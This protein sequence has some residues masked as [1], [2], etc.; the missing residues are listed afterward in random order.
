MSH[1]HEQRVPTPVLLGALTLIVLTIGLAASARDGV[2][3]E[4]IA[5]AQAPALQER[6]LRFQDRPDGAIVVTDVSDGATVAVLEPLGSGF[7]RGVMRG[8][9]RTRKL[10]SL[11]RE[12]PFRLAKEQDGRLT[13]TDPLTDRFV[14]LQAFGSENAIAFS[15]MLGQ[16]T[17]AAN[18]GTQVAVQP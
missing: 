9:F 11:P 10:E 7:V 12:H 1:H 13:L 14:D 15:P 16:H 17:A 6:M 8:M 3:A 4:R 18:A 2:R 5:Q